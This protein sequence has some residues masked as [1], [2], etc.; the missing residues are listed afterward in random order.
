MLESEVV[1]KLMKSQDA[2]LR[3]QEEARDINKLMNSTSGKGPLV[4]I[5]QRKVEKSSESNC[6]KPTVLVLDECSKSGGSDEEIDYLE[7]QLDIFNQG[8]SGLTAEVE[9]A[10]SMFEAVKM[11]D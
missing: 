6:C 9:I 10:K 8:V 5:L 1:G 7:S 2:D 3:P 4:K 11:I